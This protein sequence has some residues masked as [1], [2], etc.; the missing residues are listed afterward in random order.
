MPA[1]AT[2]DQV[3]A[4]QERVLA[5][6]ERIR[7]L[8]K[9][10]TLSPATRLVLTNAIYFNAAGDA[11]ANGAPVDRALKEGLK[12]VSEVGG[13]TVGE[14]LDAA[15][16]GVDLATTLALLLQGGAITDIREDT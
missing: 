9:P 15:P 13:A 7:E 10:G 6:L 16:E 5:G 2:L 11:C 12:R 8:L 3:A 1:I 4:V 14:A